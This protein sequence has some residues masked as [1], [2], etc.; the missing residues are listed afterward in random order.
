[1]NLSKANQ[2]LSNQSTAQSHLTDETAPATDQVLQAIQAADDTAAVE[3]VAKLREIYPEATADALVG[4]LIKQ[5]CL[6][7]GA[8]GEVISSASII[9]GV[10]VFV[11]LLFGAAA[12]V[13]LT[14]KM[15]AELVLEIAAAHQ[16]KLN[17][18]DQQNAFILVAGNSESINEL[19]TAKGETVA[20]QVTE[21]LAQNSTATSTLKL[22]GAAGAN[23]L[24]TYLIGQR[25]KIYFQSGAHLV[26]TWSES[27]EAITEADERV[28]VAW[29]AETTQRSWSLVREQTQSVTNIVVVAG[30]SLGEVLV[31]R[32]GQVS[33]TG[34]AKGAGRIA[35][36]IID[37]GMKAGSALSS[38][39]ETAGELTAGAGRGLAKGANFAGSII[40]GTGKRTKAGLIA[41]LNKIGEILSPSQKTPKPKKKKKR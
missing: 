11:S 10:G 4:M 38:R 36:P 2:E 24:A 13:Q 22:S 23:T 18:T 19:L 30:R 12:D 15:Q 32:A 3:R 33:P 1:M 16:R 5:K 27:I 26:E 25:A 31:M 20:R 21:Q 9:P 39:A 8:V 14:A 34:I 41:G 40:T 17:Q 7:T 6:Q 37:V 35:G 29:L 28:V